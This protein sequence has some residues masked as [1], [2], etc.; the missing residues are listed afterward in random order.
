MGFLNGSHGLRQGDPLSPMIFLLIAEALCLMIMLAQSKELLKG[1]SVK[2]F[3]KKVPVLQYVDGT[4]LFLDANVDMVET[5][6]ALLCLYEV[7]SGLNVNVEKLKIHQI[8]MVDNW[9]KL[10]TVSACRV[11]ARHTSRSTFSLKL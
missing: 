3:E 2:E 5:L 9:N 11:P 8:Y 4:I 1:F 6:R 7:A 10:L